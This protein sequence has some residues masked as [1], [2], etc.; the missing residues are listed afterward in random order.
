MKRV[1]TQYRIYPKQLYSEVEIV[2]RPSS[3]KV[4]GE[5]SAPIKTDKTSAILDRQANVLVAMRARNSLVQY[6]FNVRELHAW[7]R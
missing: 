5:N 4:G 6:G 3:M 7:A 1:C 2:H